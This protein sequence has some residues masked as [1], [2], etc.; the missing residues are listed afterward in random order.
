MCAKCG[1]KEYDK[2]PGR[3]G[4]IDVD[5]LRYSLGEHLKKIEYYKQQLD[6]AVFYEDVHNE[7]KKSK[8]IK[9]GKRL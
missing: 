7:K 4:L 8:E 3:V 5:A 6:K 1:I 9:N 2:L